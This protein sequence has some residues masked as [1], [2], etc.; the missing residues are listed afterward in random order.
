M[1]K[2]PS[3]WRELEQVR[4]HENFKDIG[5][6]FKKIIFISVDFKVK[7]L[8]TKCSLKFTNKLFPSSETND[9]S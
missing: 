1:R 2:N 6:T 5:F 3:L 7:L 4:T 8:I 9:F